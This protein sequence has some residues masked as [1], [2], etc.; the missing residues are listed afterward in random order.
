MTTL[1]TK[2]RA[3]P[4]DPF[5]RLNQAYQVLDM[6]DEMLDEY[7][8]FLHYLEIVEFTANEFLPSHTHVRALVRRQ[9]YRLYAYRMQAQDLRNEYRAV[10]ADLEHHIGKGEHKRK[11]HFADFSVTLESLMSET[12]KHILVKDFLDE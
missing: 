6:L 7:R 10:V 3:A 4:S 8:G 1:A 12:D 5:E 2:V 11:K 9:K